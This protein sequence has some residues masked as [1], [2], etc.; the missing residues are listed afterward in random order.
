MKV[1]EFGFNKILF[2]LFGIGF[3]LKI[4]LVGS[5]SISELFLIATAPFFLLRIN[6]RDREMF[7]IACIY[8]AL[9]ISQLVSEIVVGNSLSNSMKGL[10]ITVVSFLY[11]IFLYRYLRRDLSLLSLLVLS[12]A[13]AQIASG[14]E[15]ILKGEAL[16][17]ID[18]TESIGSK[19]LKFYIA[20]IMIDVLLFLSIITRWGM[21]AYVY[22]F[23]GLVFIVLGARS[24]GLIMFLAGV[25]TLVIE[26]WPKLLRKANLLRG[27][28]V[29]AMGGYLIYCIYATMVINGVIQ[30]GNSKQLLI[31]DNPYN[32]FELLLRGR[33]EVWVGWQA[34]MDKFFFGHGAWAHDTTGKYLHM[35]GKLKHAVA[36]DKSATLIPSH[37]VL[38]GSG[39]MNGIFAFI[40]MLSLLFFFVKRGFCSWTR[41]P[42]RYRLVF[43]SFLF[44]MMWDSLF[45]PQSH[46]RLTL[47][48]YFASIFVLYRKFARVRPRQVANH[49]GGDGFPANTAA[50]FID[51]A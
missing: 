45:S 36:V 46:L 18:F 9:F 25:V 33:T 43:V 16:T 17:E 1:G 40:A 2:L 20:P 50:G 28:A 31:C 37:S 42:Q 14:T 24:S 19:L 6:W 26:A 21:F 44:S 39:M 4:N 7:T 3:A 22:V 23:V 11:F 8:G 48:I 10:A 49:D 47:P 41:I 12:L 35:M 32:P 34:F 27:M 29:I 51:S 5:I 38:V 13:I 15:D 30:T